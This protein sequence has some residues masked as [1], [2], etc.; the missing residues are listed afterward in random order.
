MVAALLASSGLAA[1]LLAVDQDFGLVG[2]LG[3]APGPGLMA[4]QVFALALQFT[5]LALLLLLQP[6][7]LLLRLRRLVG[8]LRTIEAVVATVGLQAQAG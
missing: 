7:K 5:G 4:L 6:G 1:L 3:L 8:F 2:V